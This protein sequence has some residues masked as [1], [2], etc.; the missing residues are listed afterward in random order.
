MNDAERNSAKSLPEFSGKKMTTRRIIMPLPFRVMEKAL[1][2]FEGQ[3]WEI[4]HILFY[5]H[6]AVQG[7]VIQQNR[8]PMLE[9]VYLFIV[10]KDVPETVPMRDV[11]PKL[12][13]ASIK[14]QDDE[15]SNKR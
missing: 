13:F 9:P 14:V 3:G 5:G 4:R 10:Y 15:K 1:G 12:S 11:L 6:E 8:P 2:E 7:S